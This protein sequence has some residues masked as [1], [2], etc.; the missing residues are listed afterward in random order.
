MFAE[1][2]VFINDEEKI[3]VREPEYLDGLLPILIATPV[4]TVGMYN[5]YLHMR[6][7]VRV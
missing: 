7:P 5:M 2:T 3:I 4:N 6:H 1:T